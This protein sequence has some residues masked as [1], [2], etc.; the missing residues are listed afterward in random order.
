MQALVTPVKHS[1]VAHL[2]C[3]KI[4]FNIERPNNDTVF[5]GL[6]ILLICSTNVLYRVTSSGVVFEHATA[7]FGDKIER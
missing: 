5:V 3:N 2:Y 6:I 7:Q 4:L 1:C